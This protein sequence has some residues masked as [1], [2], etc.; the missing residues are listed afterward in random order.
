MDGNDVTK[1]VVGEAV[2]AAA[3]ASKGGLRALWAR[4]HAWWSGGKPA[5]AAP[6]AP[7]PGVIILGPGGTG[8]TTLARLLSDGPGSLLDPP[9]VY[10]DSVVTE[11]STLTDAPGVEVVVPPG[12]SHRREATWGDLLADLVAGKYRGVILV[13][14][15]GHQSIARDSYKQHPLCTAGKDDFLA[16]LLTAQR[17]DELAVLDQVAS[18]LRSVGRRVWVLTVVTKQDLWWPDRDEVERH[19]R[20]GEYHRRLATA[21]GDPPPP[22]VRHEVCTVALTIQNWTTR[23]NEKLRP[24]AEGYDGVLQGESLRRLL[25]TIDALRKWEAGL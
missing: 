12:Q 17:A 22:H 14:A 8:K 13:T 25:E 20:A 18:R 10:E 9:G 24:N 3:E 15:Y 23:A 2:K 7:E 16:R 1:A 19:Y 6:A 11:R 21:V 5:T 4:V